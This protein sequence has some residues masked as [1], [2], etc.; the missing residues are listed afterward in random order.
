MTPKVDSRWKH[1]ASDREYIIIG[2]GKMQSK[3][4]MTLA[5]TFTDQTLFYVDMEEVVI[6]S[7]HKEFWVR[8]I[9]E[10]LDGRFVEMKGE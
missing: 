2:I 3:K 7:D 10:F 6:Y 9:A 1:K 8:P 5:G 4:W